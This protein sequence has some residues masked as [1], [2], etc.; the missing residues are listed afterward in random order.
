MPLEF[1]GDFQIY[2]IVI[3]EEAAATKVSKGNLLTNFNYRNNNTNNSFICGNLPVAFNSARDPRT[4]FCS[5]MIWLIYVF[6]ISF[7]K[8]SWKEQKCLFS[9]GLKIKARLSSIKG[10]FSPYARRKIASKVIS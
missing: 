1:L 5:G 2:F 10:L 6:M 4:K 8:K 9:N 3:K 7:L